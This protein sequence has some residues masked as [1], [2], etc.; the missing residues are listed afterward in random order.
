MGKAR[1]RRDGSE[2]RPPGPPRTAGAR[3][4]VGGSTALIAILAVAAA[5][6]VAYFLQYRSASVFFDTPFFDSLTYDAWGRRIAAGE[7]VGAEPFYFAPGYAYALALVYRLISPTLPAVYVL[8][9]VLGLAD[10]VLVH[11]LTAL[12]FGRRAGL[13]AAAL[14]V[15]YAPLPFFETKLLSP[16]LAVTLLLLAL[17]ALTSAQRR[18]GA[19]R[20]A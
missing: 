3:A 8:Q 17:V 5:F 6:R 15:L 20:W 11:R 7:W 18:G 16:T 19:G 10:V 4:E 13:V 14:T 2:R 9:L 1:R 12:A